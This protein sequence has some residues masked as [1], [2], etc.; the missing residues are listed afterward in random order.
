METIPPPVV[1]TH[2]GFRVVR[3]DLIPGGTKR[4]VVP[5]LITKT[6]EYVYASPA[7][8]YAQI[9]IALCCRD[10]GKRA[11]IFVAKRDELHPLTQQAF[12]CGANIVQVP[13]GFLAVVQA[14]ARD[15][16]AENNARLLPFGL[17]SPRIRRGLADVALS[18]PFVPDEVWCVAGSGVLCRSLQM[19]WPDADHCVVKVGKQ[20][21]D[22]GKASA[23]IHPLKFGEDAKVKPPYPSCS[24]YDA[25]VWEYVLRYASPG[26]LV[27]NVGA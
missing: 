24:N 13:M 12:D 18:I 14:A 8:G 2:N 19:A 17:N 1:E 26:A 16:A 7:Q 4:R 22:V 15:Y 27:W 11:T 25:K 9:A 20:D 6:K 3:D 5:L 21:I 23:Y 10:H